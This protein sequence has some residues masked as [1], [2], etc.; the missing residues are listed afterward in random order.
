M[1]GH[2]RPHPDPRYTDATKRRLMEALRRRSSRD[3]P[4]VAAPAARWL[5]L[6]GRSTETR[7][8][9]FRELVAEMR[10]EGAPIASRGTGYYLATEVQDF[11]TTERFLRRMG[12]GQLATAAGI[13]RS[14]ARAVAAGQLDL[15]QIH[16]TAPGRHAHDLY[17]LDE[18]D[19]EPPPAHRQEPLF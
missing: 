15:S 5:G 11:E 14:H 10:T 2:G 3:R 8:R 13:R 16:S 4:I 6:P 7:R 18:P 12:L 9:R 19:P 17:R 1:P